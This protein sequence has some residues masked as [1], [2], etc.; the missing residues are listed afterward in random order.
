MGADLEG[1]TVFLIPNS[2]FFFLNKIKRPIDPE[3]KIVNKID[4]IPAFMKHEKVKVR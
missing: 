4:K 3:D 2:S 1:P